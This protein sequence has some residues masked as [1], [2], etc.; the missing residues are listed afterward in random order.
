[1]KKIIKIS[2][3]LSAALCVALPLASC[4]SNVLEGPTGF[5]LDEN[6]NLSWA[7]VVNARSYLIDIKNVETGESQEAA[8]RRESIS[9]SYLA[10]GDYDIRIR[11]VGDG[12]HYRNS[13]WSAIVSFNRAY[14]SG[15]Q[16]RLID[17]GSEYEVAAV[18]LT[19]TSLVLEDSYRGKPV[20]SIGNSAFRRANKLESLTVG[21]Y[22]T[23]I[24]EGA[25]YNCVALKEISIPDSVTSIGKEAFQAC[26]SLESFVVPAGVTEL[27]ASTF[28]YCRGLKEIELS[29]VTEIGDSVF[30]NCSG[31]EEFTISDGVESIGM[32]SFAAANALKEVTLGSGLTEI[33]SDAF[34]QCEALEKVNFNDAGNLKTIGDRAFQLSALSSLELP[35]GLET[36]GAGAFYYANKLETIGSIPDSVTQIGEYA[37]FATKYY[38]DIYNAGTEMLVYVDDWLI[39]CVE[40]DGKK[41]INLLAEDSQNV[42]NTYCMKEETVGIADSAFAG[43]QNL[44]KV[45][46]SKN[47]KYVGVTAFASCPM[48][49]SFLTANSSLVSLNKGALA[50]NEALY[51]VEFDTSNKSKL[52]EIGEQAF[53]KCPK[54]TYRGSDT[55]SDFIPSTLDRIGA[56]AFEGTGLYDNADENGV[57]YADDWVVGLVKDEDERFP[58][59]EVVK[60]RDDVRGIADY[61]FY[62]CRELVSVDN[63][64]N[65]LKI[66]KGAFYN[67]T[68]LT[69]FTMSRD[70]QRIEDYAFYNCNELDI[71]DLPIDLRSIGRSA[72]YNCARIY[73]IDMPDS[74]ESM[75]DF[76]YYGCVNLRR[77]TLGNNLTEV[78]EYTF[79]RCARLNYVTI[80]SNI[81]K[82]GKS[83]FS[84]CDE[85]K[86]LMMEEGV[87]EIGDFAF[88]ST[89]IEKISLPESV[90]SVGYAA[91]AQCANVEEIDLGRVETIGDFAFAENYGV[92]NLV[93]PDSV[94]TIGKGAFYSLGAAAED[95]EGNPLGGVQCVIVCGRLD[96]IEAHAFYGCNA[97]TVFL[98]DG[99][100]NAEWGAGWNSSRRPTVWGVT[101]S[102]DKSYVVSLTVKGDTFEYF[103]TLNRLGSPYREGYSFAGWSLTENGSD[104]AYTTSNVASAPVGTVLYAVY[105]HE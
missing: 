104:I 28:A 49:Y 44:S 12:S 43:N 78:G 98:E 63:S 72:F 87:E 60:L 46:L 85:L 88:R 34:S 45:E 73:Q 20:T 93:I 18:S 16:Y 91:F 25:F 30:D 70:L 1:M 75:G 41:L 15:C 59:V 89:A 4:S 22:V 32:R 42:P 21:K 14:E 79:Y 86:V 37:F 103:N 35:E 95:E 80:P 36:I 61:T 66:G 55:S 99:N 11:A 56:R 77:V 101:L 33:K 7:P 27:E 40:K 10:M 47:V 82:I 9:L 94:K 83:A 57:V 102:E 29:N 2:A 97:A 3:A 68:A 54:L 23:T 39:G 53:Y 52:K 62:N 17:N 5:S 8:S 51:Q 69:G 31:L 38:T 96:G 71:N 81:K 24:G 65:V 48:L 13:E 92:R 105:I 74:L 58:S 64:F 6:Y 90:K 84:G 19:A 100:R 26:K 76:A 50:F 67:C